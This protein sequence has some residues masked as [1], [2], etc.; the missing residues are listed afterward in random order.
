[1]KN[2]VTTTRHGFVVEDITFRNARKQSAIDSEIESTCTTA[3]SKEVPISMTPEQV[4]T[5]Y[6][7]L[8]EETLNMNEK[9]VY[10]TTIKWIDEL[11]NL[12]KEVVKKDIEIETLKKVNE[13]IPVEDIK[14]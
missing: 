7:N 11:F 12:R 8:A 13:D 2:D 1:M 14:D 5:F 3:T 9:K 4:K 6:K 10:M